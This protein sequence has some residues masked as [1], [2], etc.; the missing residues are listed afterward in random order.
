MPLIKSSSKK[1]FQKNVE[2]EMAANPEK[3]KRSQN[4]AIAYSIQRK[5]KGKKYAKGGMIDDQAATE[6]RPMPSE[7]DRD[8][9]M[10]GRNSSNHSLPESSWTD[11]PEIRDAQSPSPTK[12]S[13]PKQLGSDAYS[14]RSK[15]ES[16]ESI[17]RLDSE[18]PES[19]RAQPKKRYDED[20]AKRQGP[21]VSDMERQHS[22]G[23]AP[24]DMAIEG[25]DK[26]DQAQSDMKK[27][28]SPLGRYAKGGRVDMRPMDHGDELMER[29]DELDMQSR[30]SDG[31]HDEQPASW[32][33]EDGAKRQGPI[34]EGGFKYAD[35]D[36]DDEGDDRD[37]DM[38][39][40]REGGPDNPSL[41]QSMMAKGGMIEMDMDKPKS[42]AEAIRRKKMMAEGGYPGI[43]DSQ[44]DLQY[45]QDEHL[46]LEDDLSYD[47]ARKKTYFDES[48]LDKQPMN[49]NEHGDE[50]AD[51]DSHN[52]KMISK[53]MKS[54]R[55]KR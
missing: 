55:A 22:D 21:M 24:Y 10:V 11:E 45:N 48:Q 7:L 28:Q 50:L 35:E 49:S 4:L 19:D 18:Y 46:N 17:D 13:R 6:R 9:K 25:D 32:R 26:E 51:E 1:A 30:L 44:A 38:L 53:I 2:T 34:R 14:Q 37:K 12:L 23:K 33:D 42:I 47:A 3:S 43:D 27:M 31:S 36:N 29:E 5:N 8:A 52:I 41:A 54:M 20:G 40:Q 15:E 16:D 39:I